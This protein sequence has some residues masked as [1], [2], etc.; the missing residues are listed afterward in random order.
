MTKMDLTAGGII[1]GG[2]SLLYVGFKLAVWLTAK[3]DCGSAVREGHQPMLD[4]AR[5][6]EKVQAILPI[7]VRATFAVS[8]SDDVWTQLDHTIRN[9]FNAYGGVVLTTG[10]RL[11]VDP[12][13]HLVNTGFAK[14]IAKNVN[15][16]KG[17][18]VGSDMDGGLFVC[19]PR[20][21]EMYYLDVTGVCDEYPSIYHLIL[22]CLG[23]KA[24]GSGEQR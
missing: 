6:K 22:D 23:H 18:V 15:L 8:A 2:A 17:F 12:I 9:F 20:Q 24:A 4:L 19:N 10:D 21:R 11:G 3:E 7:A 1:I 16:S 13:V 5:A 14:R